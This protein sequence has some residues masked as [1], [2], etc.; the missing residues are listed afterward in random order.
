MWSTT[1]EIKFK[2][3]IHTDTSTLWRFIESPN[4]LDR[5]TPDWMKF[6]ILSNP[7]Q[8]MYNGLLIEYSV[9]LPI[10][11]ETRWLTEIKHIEPGVSFVDEQRQG[12]YSFWYHEHRIEDLGDGTCMMHDILRYQPPFGPLGGIVNRLVISKML[13]EIFDYRRGA[14]DEIFPERLQA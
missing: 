4:N 12:P 2:Q 9:G 5:I 1:Y 7:P 6:N 14:M 11:G 10:L 8:V 3:K 13:H